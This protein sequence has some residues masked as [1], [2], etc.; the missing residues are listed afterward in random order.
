MRGGLAVLPATTALVLGSVGAVLARNTQLDP[1]VLEYQALAREMSLQTVFGGVREPIWPVLFVLPVR[2]LG[3]QS[4]LALR[5]VGVLGFVLLIIAVQLLT[6]RLY[7]AAWGIVS[8]LLLAATPWL[9][10]QASRGLREETSAALILLLCLG[11]LPEK[12]SRRSFVGL[13]ALAGVSGLL[14]WDAMV[15]MLPVLGLALLIRRPPAKV[16]IVGPAVT[17]LI[18]APLLVANYVDH[19]DPFY[20]SNIHARFFTNIEFHDQPGFPTSAEL[21]TN[22]FAGP[23]T[24]WTHYVFGLHSPQE[25]V[26]RA[27]RAFVI[28]PV[29]V[30]TNAMLGRSFYHLPFRLAVFLQPFTPRIIWVFA[31]AGALALLRT[32]AWM[33]PV[34][35]GTIILLYSP[36]ASLIDD[37][38]VLPVYPLMA[39]CV[40]EAVRPSKW[41]PAVRAARIRYRQAIAVEPPLA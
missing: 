2:L 1:D 13:F 6:T 15:V 34:V 17:V 18:V 21:A 36:I 25:L 20:H 32:R 30:T 41:M 33:I 14:R 7:G 24:T 39:I 29:D 22:A 16:W 28:I 31:V 38:L 35:L 5:F 9:V 10:F 40:I 12:I 37:R 26:S 3:D 8:A 23:Q 4:P 27:A 11:L 19:G